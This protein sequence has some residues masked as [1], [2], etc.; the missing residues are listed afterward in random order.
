MGFELESP[1][2]QILYRLSHQGSPEFVTFCQKLKMKVFFSRWRSGKESTSP[3]QEM[4]EIWV[5]SLNQED[6]LE[7]EM[8]TH[9]SILPWKIPRTEKPGRL[10]SIRSQWVGHT[11]F[12]TF[13]P[14]LAAIAR[15]HFLPVWQVEGHI[16]LHWISGLTVNLGIFSLFLGRKFSP[17]C[18]VYSNCLFILILD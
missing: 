4:Q 18:F 13:L 15:F 3:V 1:T 9:S 5:W 6:P 12:S 10:K 17:F 7:K 2:L 16:V 11:F 14:A 8:A